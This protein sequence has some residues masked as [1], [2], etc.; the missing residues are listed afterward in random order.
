MTGH[1]Y[2]YFVFSWYCDT[3]GKIVS[4]VHFDMELDMRPYCHQLH[5]HS[6]TEQDFL[7]QLSGVI[8]HMG[9]G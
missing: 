4:H 6:Y 2:E 3:R 8:I 1:T 9:T 5:F 7:Y